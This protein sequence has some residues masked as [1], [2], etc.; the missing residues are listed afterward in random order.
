MDSAF[1]ASLRCKIGCSELA[2]SLDAGR[3]HFVAQVGQE[4]RVRIEP[5]GSLERGDAVKLGGHLEHGDMLAWLVQF[6]GF[7]GLAW[8]QAPARLHTINPGVEPIYFGIH[9][10]ALPHVHHAA[11]LD[12]IKPAIN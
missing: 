1:S 7:K 6:K 8:E 9:T 10:P 11:S 5:A 3:Q 12:I 2:P 4:L